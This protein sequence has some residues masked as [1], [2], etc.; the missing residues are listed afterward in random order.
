MRSIDVAHMFIARQGEARWITNLSLNKLV[1]F[2]QVESLKMRNGTPLFEDAIEAWAYGP[3]EPAVYHAFKSFGRS[4]VSLP[5]GYVEPTGDVAD[6]ASAVVDAV[7][8][9]YG[10]LS[11]FDLVNLTHRPGSAWSNTYVEGKDVVITLDDILASDDFKSVIDTSNTFSAGV[12]RV[13]EKWPNALRLL[14][15]A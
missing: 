3:V 10:S 9:K 14:Q 5:D 1:Y 11:A 6:A 8:Q 12:R 7:M 4:P 2:A 13:E 15:D